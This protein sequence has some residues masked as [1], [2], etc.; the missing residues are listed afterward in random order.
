MVWKQDLA[1][2]K[3]D[4]KS[5]E[6]PARPPQPLPKRPGA[7]ATQR[8]LEEEDA[9]FLD[10]MGARRPA[11]V[12]KPGPLAPQAPTIASPP[13]G[14]GDEGTAFLEALG[15]LKGL[16]PLGASTLEAPSRVAP[17]TPSL[18]ATP[19]SAPPPSV[20]AMDAPDMPSDPPQPPVPARP[21]P[22]PLLIHLAAGMA[23]DVDGLLDLRGHSL[24]DARDRLKEAVLDGATLGWRTLHVMLGPSEV[25][26][27]GF[28]AFLVGPGAAPIAR[29][30]QAPIPMGGPHAWILYYSAPGAPT[31][32]METP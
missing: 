30:A 6:A 8:P 10:S 12:E 13:T 28:L 16:R 29:Y 5:D 2:L 17:A 14:A 25:L 20:P 24:A 7:P 32:V 22:G 23:V 31:R 9:L 11:P 19:E 27:Q 15:G 26:K 18:P 4:L 1:K 21:Q 3:Q